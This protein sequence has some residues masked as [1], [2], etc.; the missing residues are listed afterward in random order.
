LGAGITYEYYRELGRNSIDDNGMSI[1]SVANAGDPGAHPLFNAFWDGTKMVYGN[2]EPTQVYPF[3]A[4]LDVVG[5][6][7]T[8]GVTEFSGGLV[9]FNQPGAMNEAYS[10][11]FGNAIQVNV[12]GI[13][14]SSPNAGLLGETL[15]RKRRPR[16]CALRDLND[17]RTI[18]DYVYYMVGT[19]NGGVHLNSSI[20]AGALWDIREQ[21]G[22]DTADEI[23]YK[24]L[25]EYTT[26]L[27]DFVDG[28]RGVIAAAQALGYGPADV[29]A[30]EHAF[31]AKG[32]VDGWDTAATNDAQLVR[33]DVVS[34]DSFGVLSPHQVSGNRYIIADYEDKTR[35]FTTPQQLFVGN[36]DGTGSV[37]KVSEDDDP[38]TLSDD[39]PDIS[40]NYAVWSHVTANANGI[41]QYDVDGR[42]LGEGVDVIA[43]GKGDE[44]EP[45][46]SGDL[47]AWT[48]FGREGESE[49]WA[50]YLGEPK[51][52]VAGGK[53]GKRFP[54]AYGDWVSWQGTHP[55]ISS[56]GLKNVKTG[57]KMVIRSRKTFL[58][59]PILGA[60]RLVWMED[61]DFK[62][63]ATAIAS[64]DLSTFK[65]TTLIRESSR[66]APEWGGFGESPLLSVNEEF[67]AYADES[68]LLDSFHDPAFPAARVGR[69]L[70]MMPASGGASAPVTC[71][72]GDQAF[73]ALGV[74]G[75]VSW[76]DTSRGRTDLMSDSG[77]EPAC[78]SG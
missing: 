53:T 26:P 24:A 59:D 43:G 67:V 12:E 55:F 69:D 29:A 7:L 4:A 15:C 49:I 65:K 71:N 66:R 32:I 5:H 13:D 39:L 45:S 56:I 44:F 60:G 14:M 61:P 34:V 78:Q 11:Y 47:V 76:L 38:A 36:L 20:Y 10:D 70:W 63:D 54:Q 3:S 17:G 57:K 8:H 68:D 1:V 19:D 25:T 22:G 74:G 42:A 2:P 48:Q 23:T 77:P 27:D 64:L 75:L 52:R 50:R 58:L 72:R 31:D 6:E 28:R 21:L 18:D 37:L 40:G 51:F 30:I 33:G 41:P 46:I 35:V 16:M 9:Y 62:D 73:P